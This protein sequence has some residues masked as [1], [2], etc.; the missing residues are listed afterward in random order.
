VKGS[1]TVDMQ[2]G[3]VIRTTLKG[4]Y[5]MVHFTLTVRMFRDAPYSLLPEECRIDAQFRFLGNR[6]SNRYDAVYGLSDSIPDSLRQAGELAQMAAVRPV[7][8]TG[9]EEDML[10]DHYRRQAEKDSLRTTGQVKKSWART[11][12]WDAIGD[13]VLN[14]VKSRFGKNDEGYLR[15]NPILNPLYMGYSDRRGFTYKFDMRLNYNFS[16]RYRLT[17]RLK[18]GYAFKQKQFYF[19][20]PVRLTYS[21]SKNRYVE[22]ELNN[23]S[24]IRNGIMNDYVKE[25]LGEHAFDDNERAVNFKDLRWKVITNFDANRHWGFQAGMILHRRSAVEKDFYRALGLPVAYRSA[26]P[27]LSVQYRPLGYGGPTLT[28]DYERGIKGMMRSDMDYER[29]EFDAQ[30]IIRMRCMRSLQMRFGYGFYTNKGKETTRFFL[31]Y[32][33]FRDIN[34]EGGWNDS[35]SGRFELVNRNWYNASDYYIRGNFTYESPLLAASWLP[36][37]GRFIEAERVY[38]NILAIQDIWPY[39][40]A[41]YG[42]TTRLF[43]IG[44]FMSHCEGR[45]DR[46][47]FKLGFELFRDW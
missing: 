19:R 42:F 17:S 43:S 30:W 3:Q 23:G 35:W 8:L 26:A 31:D 21:K 2:T 20:L 4:E 33:N 16:E 41:G 10:E 28:A 34:I 5:D 47:G 45:F 1:A 44:V 36:V 12:L 18:A 9:E 38:F 7:P 13:N 24:W 22:M 37:V 32:E 29:W 14:R 11:V 40:E 27:L 15:I 6:I 39:T 46:F 25:I